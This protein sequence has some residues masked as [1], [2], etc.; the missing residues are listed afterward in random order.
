LNKKNRDLELL[1]IAVK[2]MDGAHSPYSGVRVGAAVLGAD[3]QIY[4]GCNVENAALG[5]S[6]CAERIALFNAVAHGTT[7]I[8]AVVFTSNHPKVNSPCGSCR[9]VMMELA[10]QARVVYGDESE[11]RKVWESPRELLPD[12]FD[13]DWRS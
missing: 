3:G 1:G 2:A 6:V 8:E 9:Q 10:P 7:K 13:G 12:A 4:P 11:V 5:L